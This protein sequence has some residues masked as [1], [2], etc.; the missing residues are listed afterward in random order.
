MAAPTSLPAR[1]CA[2]NTTATAG[3]TYYVDAAIGSDSN[4]ATQAKS[5]AT[6]WA[7]LQHALD[8]G[9]T[10]PTAGSNTP[11]QIFVRGTDGV[12]TRGFTITDDG[13]SSAVPAGFS[14]TSIYQPARDLAFPSDSPLLI[15]NMAGERVL[16]GFSFK[17]SK[18]DT[19]VCWRASDVSSKKGMVFDSRF[20]AGNTTFNGW[21][22]NGATHIELYGCEVRNNCWN[23]SGG[24]IYVGAW[25]FGGI[26]RASTDIQIINCY[27]HHN[28]GQNNGAHGIYFGGTTGTQLIGAVNGAVY[29]CVIAYNFADNLSPHNA[30]QGTVFAHNHLVGW[31]GGGASGGTATTPVTGDANAVNFTDGSTVFAPASSGDPMTKDCIWVNNILAENYAYGLNF[32]DATLNGTGN[33]E[34]NNLYHGNGSGAIRDASST[35]S[36]LSTLLS[37]DPLFTAYSATVP[38][39]T[40]FL[41]TSSSPCKGAGDSAYTPT[42]DFT[43]AARPRSDIG[44]YAISGAGG[45]SAPSRSLLGV[46]V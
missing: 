21:Y 39:A 3:N 2:A 19:Y 9:I 35:L 11:I 6:P 42:F 7:T 13:P 38:S 29:N 31:G 24:G 17:H 28:G 25:S 33:V 23:A 40:N 22:T 1:V 8:S 18:N 44:A 4:T 34:K 36:K 45:S 43:G 46:G 16:F 30:A 41:P 14:S 10:I 15:S 26:N 37:N 32:F 5:T 20:P 27:V 12:T